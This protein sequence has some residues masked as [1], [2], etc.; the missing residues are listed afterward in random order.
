M[1]NGSETR[2]RSPNV[3]FRVSPDERAEIDRKAERAGLTIG[4][5]A[6]KTLLD[7]EPPRQVRRPVAEKA[8]LVRILGEL[9]KVGGNLNQFARSANTGTV[10]YEDDI[11][12]ELD[13]L[14]VVRDAILSALGRTP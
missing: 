7:A 10:L 9:G 4:S 8:I 12:R 1:S 5:Y 11:A 13:G 6:R 2:V 14:R 3:T